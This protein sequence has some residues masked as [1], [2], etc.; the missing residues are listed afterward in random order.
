MDAHSNPCGVL[1]H[2]NSGRNIAEPVSDR[3]VLTLT[4]Q[5]PFAIR[6]RKHVIRSR[7]ADLADAYA[8]LPPSHRPTD[9]VTACLDEGR[10]SPRMIHEVHCS[11]LYRVLLIL[12][13]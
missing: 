3:G 2:T 1:N 7:D 13:T 9:H 5:P 10:A 4:A 8:L 6:P 11:W 12:N